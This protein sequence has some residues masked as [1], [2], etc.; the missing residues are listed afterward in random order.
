ML[1]WASSSSPVHFLG[2]HVV[3]LI[4]WI[5]G[6]EFIK[7]YSVSRSGVFKEQGIDT[8]DFYQTILNS[9]VVLPLM[10]RTAGLSLKIR[11]MSLSLK[12]IL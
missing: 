6:E 1:S 9:P 7:V 8:P 12:E 10:W 4:R 3:D 2:S 5:T 11:R